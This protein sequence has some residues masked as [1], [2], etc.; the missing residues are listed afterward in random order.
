MRAF[1]HRTTT[2]DTIARSVY[3]RRMWQKSEEERAA[4]PHLHLLSSLSRR[5]DKVPALRD[6]LWSLERATVD[7]I[8]SALGHGDPDAV[9]DRGELLG[10]LIGP[11]IRKQRHVLRN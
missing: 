4:V 1:S 8:W 3:S 5:V 2:V 7:R 6:W 10:R 9:S 11:R